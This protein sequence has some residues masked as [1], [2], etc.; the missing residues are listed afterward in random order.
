MTIAKSS[1]G[2]IDK[3]KRDDGDGHLNVELPI[4]PQCC[5]GNALNA[6]SCLFWPELATRVATYPSGAARVLFREL[7]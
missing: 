5:A 2:S 4:R 6:G 7:I 3:K 1:K